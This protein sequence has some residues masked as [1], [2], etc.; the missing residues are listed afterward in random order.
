MCETNNNNRI[1]KNI[2]ISVI[3]STTIT[4]EL[5]WSQINYDTILE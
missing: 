3:T 5:I 2:E 4:I 1:S